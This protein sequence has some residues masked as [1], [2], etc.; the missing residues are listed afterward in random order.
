MFGNARMSRT[1]RLGAT[2]RI[3]YCVTSRR[4]MAWSARNVKGLNGS[5]CRRQIGMAGDDLAGAETQ[6]GL[7]QGIAVMS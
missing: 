5:K 4:Y 7:F 1:G 3:R 2:S 6:E